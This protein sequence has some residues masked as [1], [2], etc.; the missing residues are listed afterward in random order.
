MHAILA[1]LIPF[2]VLILFG[3]PPATAGTKNTVT[4]VEYVGSKACQACHQKQYKAW[5]NSLHTQM[6]RPIAKGDFKNVKADL[7]VA[8][9]PKPDQYGLGLRHRGLVQGGAVRLP[10]R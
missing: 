6:V 7:T 4:G 2:L 1:S 10:G 9:A 5:E 8:N 3:V